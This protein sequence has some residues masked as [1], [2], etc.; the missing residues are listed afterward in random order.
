MR[1]I[2][3]R[4]SRHHVGISL[5]L[6][7]AAGAALS[8]SESTG[9][10]PSGTYYG[11]VTQMG[12]GTGR[13][14]VTLDG[15]G[16]HTELGVTFTEAALSGL[17]DDP[18]EFFF[19]LP[20]RMLGTPFRHVVINW[21]PHGHPP[22]GVYTVPHLDVHF[23]M[24]TSQVRE[25]IDLTDPA[26]AAKAAVKPSAELLPTGYVAGMASSW[27]GLHWR[28]P[29]G[30]EFSGQPFTKTVIYG[31][32]DGAVTFL[33]PMLAKSFLESKPSNVKTALKLPATF[34][35]RGYQ[36]TSYTVHWNASTREYRVVLTDLV[37]R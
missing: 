23:Y 31:S 33:E 14:F 36:P 6:M 25:A 2:A 29:S 1:P 34:G 26:V 5:V 11:S 7:A 24:I 9:P 27:M 12:G 17:G 22:A 15:S 30:P 21:E 32:Y 20:I 3:S 16:T 35:S 13:S 18:D 8:C 28:D 19:D 4:R 37:L 10:D